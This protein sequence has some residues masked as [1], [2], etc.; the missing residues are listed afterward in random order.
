[1]LL[2]Y[3]GQKKLVFVRLLRTHRSESCHNTHVRNKWNSL[4]ARHEIS[5]HVCLL[6]LHRNHFFSHVFL[7]ILI[8]VR[9]AMARA[10]HLHI[11]CSSWRCSWHRRPMS[12]IIRAVEIVEPILIGCCIYHAVCLLKWILSPNGWRFH[13]LAATSHRQARSCTLSRYAS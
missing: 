6:G 2:Y 9:I 1:M 13:F 8:F 5:S 12:E 7:L 3:D 11:F 4:I 10:R